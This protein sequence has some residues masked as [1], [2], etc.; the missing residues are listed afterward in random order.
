MEEMKDVN[1][2]TLP[3]LTWN[4]FLCED[5]TFLP[6]LSI[7]STHKILAI[8]KSRAKNMAH[9]LAGMDG[10]ASLNRGSAYTCRTTQ[11]IMIVSAII[12]RTVVNARLEDF[13]F[14]VEEKFRFDFCL[15][16]AKW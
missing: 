9:W 1:S 5:L 7:T 11:P 8:K 2:T 15:Y 13:D 3:Y 6:H 12:I 10:A 14:S 4:L 16:I